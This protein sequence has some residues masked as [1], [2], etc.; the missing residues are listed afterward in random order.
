MVQVTVLTSFAVLAAT[1][2]A[3]IPALSGYSVVWSEDFNGASGDPVSNANWDQMVR[4]RFKNDNN[5]EQEYVGTSDVA[6]LSGD[7]QLYIIPKKQAAGYFTSA[8]LSSKATFHCPIG[9]AL[10]IQAEIRVPDFTNAPAQYAGLW[11]AFW[12]LG[13]SIRVAGGNGWPKCG[14]FDILEVATTLTNKNQGTLHYEWTNGQ[15][16]SSSNQI[17]YSGGDYHTWAIKIDRRNSDWTQQTLTWYRDGTAF[18]TVT[19]GQIN[20]FSVWELLAYKSHFVILNMAVGGNFSGPP[21]SNTLGG[22]DSSMRVRY[23]AAY[24]SN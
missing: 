2:W 7:G 4:S 12:T 15:H 3:S 11:P 16:R 23:V 13:Q 21:T 18:H 10:V 1:A 17:I 8:R 20:D 6:H 9:K 14:E 22:F 19:G 5:E 24:E